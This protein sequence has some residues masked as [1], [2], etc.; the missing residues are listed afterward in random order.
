MW[1]GL[2]VRV[3]EVIAAS[4]AVF[5][6]HFYVVAGGNAFQHHSIEESYGTSLL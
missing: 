4:I 1:A 3:Q 5:S 6:I 2:R